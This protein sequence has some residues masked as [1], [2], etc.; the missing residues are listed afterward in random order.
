LSTLAILSCG[1]SDDDNET[2]GAWQKYLPSL[3]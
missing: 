1:G 2:S 3:R